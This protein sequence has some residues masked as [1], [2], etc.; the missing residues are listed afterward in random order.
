MTLPTGASFAMGEEQRITDAMEALAK[1]PHAP[2]E[3]SVRLIL[4]VHREYPKHVVVGKN[5][6]DSPKTVLVNS[7]EEESAATRTGSR[8]TPKLRDF[9]EDA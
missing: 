4:H 8:R 7:A 9:T 6:D 1:D 2:R 3:I 5:E